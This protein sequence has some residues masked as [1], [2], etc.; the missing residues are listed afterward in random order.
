[1]PAEGDITPSGEVFGY[2][3]ITEQY[4]DRYHMPVMHTETNMSDVKGAPLWLKK[5][6]SNMIRLKEDGVPIVGFT[7]YSLTDQMD[8][9]SLLMEDKGHVNTLG[10]YDLNRKIRPVGEEYRKIV[11][12]WTLPLGDESLCLN[13]RHV[14][15]KRV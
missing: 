7:W 13:Q 11:T 5:Q 3:V 6:W 4:F 8:W 2:Y 14:P 15:R 10:L 12:Q 1:V 9:D